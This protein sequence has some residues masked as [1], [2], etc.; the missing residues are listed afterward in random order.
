MGIECEEEIKLLNDRELTLKTL[1]ALEKCNFDNKKV[2][3]I[4]PDNTRSAPMKLFYS[5]FKESLLKRVQKLDFII[6]LGTHPPM[7]PDQIFNQFGVTPQDSELSGISIFNHQWDNFLQLKTI[8]TLSREEVKNISGGL[9]NESIPVKINRMI[10][11][12]D[13]LVILGPVFPHEV[14]GF[15]G[16]YKYFFPGISGA[17][18]TNAFHWLS[19]LITNPRII[20]QKDTPVQQILRSAARFVNLPVTAFC[21]VMKGKIPCG[22]FVGPV[23]EAWSKAVNLSAQVNI[24][25]KPKPFKKVISIAPMMYNEL[26]VGGKCV[27]KLEPVVDDGGEII[28]YAPHI[29]EIS[30]THG[31]HLVNVGYHNRDYFLSNWEKYSGI[32]KGVLAHSTHVKGIG[33]YKNCEEYSRINVILSTGLSA[34]I[35]SLINLC[36]LDP[37]TFNPIEYKNREEEGILV[38]PNAGEML[39]RLIDG[40]VP[41]V[42]RLA[43]GYR[44]F[45]RI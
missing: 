4:V 11:D 32:P 35:C 28:I 10:F 37:F 31:K 14:V 39:F 3:I 6:A 21:F 8:G 24:V 18:I 13:E 1:D 45:N 36:F 7:T 44:S 17:E 25:Y 23:I 22:L 2:L 40:T 16:G 26:W 27:Y 30:I 42:D 15:S 29:N 12:Y 34:E 9:L 20:G 33:T 41:N 19:A 43:A 38:V 5:V